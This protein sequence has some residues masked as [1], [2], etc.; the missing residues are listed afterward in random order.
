MSFPGPNGTVT[1]TLDDAFTV[2][3]NGLPLVS[4]AA[5]DAGAA[6]AGLGTGTF[7]VSRAGS[8][9]GDLAVSWSIGG[10]AT[11]GDDFQT[12]TRSATIPDGQSSIT[13]TLTP[14]DDQEAEPSETV[15]L[16]IAASDSYSIGSSAAATIRIADD[17]GWT[18]SNTYPIVDT[19]QTTF[20]D[21]TDAILEPTAGQPFYGQD[22]HYAGNQP[23]YQRHH[24]RYRR[25]ARGPHSKQL[26][27]LLRVCRGQ[28][29][30]ARRL[31]PG[32]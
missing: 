14:V 21:D 30:R 32:T 5:T 31:E 20:Y 27:R 29:R 28:R 4:V 7:V 18:S 26:A 16:S 25:S 11:E 23:Q 8:T 19:G 10:S 12:L 2:L 13:L 3:G 9:D 22:A 6:E 17:D 24:G 15:V 1:L